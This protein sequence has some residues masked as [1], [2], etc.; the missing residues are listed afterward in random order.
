MPLPTQCEATDANGNVL[1]FNGTTWTTAT[2][3]DVT[4][5][6]NAVSCPTTSFC[7]ATDASGNAVVY[8][9]LSTTNQLTWDTNSSL[10][11]V[12]ADSTNDY[13][14]GPNNEPVEQVALSS[15]TPTYLTYTPSDS[16]WLA[17]NN[18]GQEVAF[19]RYDAFGNLASGT[20]ASPF[21]YSGQYTDSSTGLVNDR[22]RFYESQT[23]SFTTR[24]PAFSTTDTAYT[25]SGGDPVNGSDPTGLTGGAPPPTPSAT[26]YEYSFDL[27][28]L[29]TPEDV[30][31]FARDDCSQ[32]FPIS[33]CINDFQAGQT[34]LLQKRVLWGLYTQSFPVKVDVAADTYWIFEALQGHP[35]GPGRKITFSFTSGSA[36]ADVDLHVYTSSNG[37]LLTHLPVIRNIDFFVAHETW[38]DFAVNIKQDDH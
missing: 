3:I 6:I 14:Y 8:Q 36:C 37:S 38:K 9:T 12:L 28:E 19:W 25:Y 1:T 35:E 15:S 13:I 21:G 18:A 10:S 24:D 27:G 31:S 33:G 32:V 5:S 29:G 17:T 11:L 26:S 2:N 23:G 4:R 22:A 30:A 7:A 34:M 20:P 16:S